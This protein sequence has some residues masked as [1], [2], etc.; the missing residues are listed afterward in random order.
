MSDLISRRALLDKFESMRDNSK[1]LNRLSRSVGK[2]IAETTYKA[3]TL[4]MHFLKEA[5]AVDAVPV[6]HGRWEARGFMGHN[7]SVCGALND[8]DT[9][10]CPN[11]GADM[12]G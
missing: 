1:T 2:T 11:C 8:I 3:I 4:C 12:R 10:Y 5:P 6:V 7:C 9:N